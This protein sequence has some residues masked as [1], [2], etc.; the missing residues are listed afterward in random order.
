MA[1]EFEIWYLGLPVEKNCWP[2]SMGVKWWKKGWRI[3][4][5]YK[6][7][8]FRGYKMAHICWR[9][10]ALCMLTKLP[11]DESTPSP[12]NELISCRKDKS[13]QNSAAMLASSKWCRKKTSSMFVVAS[14]FSM[15]FRQCPK[16]K[17]NLRKRK[18]AE[19]ALLLH[20]FDLI[21]RCGWDL[22]GARKRKKLF[23]QLSW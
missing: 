19:R 6:L 20:F 11:V 15:P 3:S 13:I 4:V 12:L 2:F 23:S 8:S 10:S 9:N 16:Q 18:S 7:T 14:F 21:I 5:V 22:R 1:K 17:E